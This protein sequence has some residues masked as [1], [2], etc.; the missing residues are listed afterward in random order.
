MIM[1]E[2][3]TKE[4]E[5]KYIIKKIR[6]TTDDILWHGTLLCKQCGCEIEPVGTYTYAPKDYC[7]TI[8][9]F[10]QYLD[11]GIPNYCNNC[12]AKLKDKE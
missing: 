7:P 4:I 8:E 5:T 6:T 2:K 10:S 3:M 9:S 11:C 12:G 1:N